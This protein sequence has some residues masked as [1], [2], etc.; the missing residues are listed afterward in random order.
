VGSFPVPVTMTTRVPST[1]AA[2]SGDDQASHRWG[3]GDHRQVGGV[4]LDD[5]ALSAP[6]WGVR[7]DRGPLTPPMWLPVDEW[8]T[9][10]QVIT[11]WRAGLPEWKLSLTRG[12][13]FVVCVLSALAP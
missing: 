1:G 7:Q 11:A 4:D 2:G 8:A 5:V 3:V 6:W 12:G 10:E 9:P 13:A